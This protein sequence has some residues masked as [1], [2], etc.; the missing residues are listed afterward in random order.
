[1]YEKVVPAPDAPKVSAS[2]VTSAQNAKDA[3]TSAPLEPVQGRRLFATDESM[4]HAITGHGVD[5]TRVRR[6]EFSI[7]SIIASY[8][9]AGISQ[10]ALV[11]LSGQ[12]KRSLPKRTDGLAAAGYIEKK[13]IMTSGMQTSWCTLQRFVVPPANAAPGAEDDPAMVFTSNGIDKEKFLVLVMR[14]MKDAGTMTFAHLR[15]VLVSSP[16]I[17]PPSP[18]WILIRTVLRGKIINE[19]FCRVLPTKDSRFEL[20]CGT[21]A[22]LSY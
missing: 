21:S 14:L 17:S 11:K 20:S 22:C 7:L 1:M 19:I 2:A 13:P 16:S 4:W 10:P 5:F 18:D 15:H 8:G 9:P 6:L 3:T 12:D